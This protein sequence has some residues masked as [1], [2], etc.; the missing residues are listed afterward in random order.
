MA[1]QQGEGENHRH[2]GEDGGA[3]RLRGGRDEAKQPVLGKH[4]D[5]IE[6][7]G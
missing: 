5:P 3:D 2:D 4:E 6:L 7:L 1:K